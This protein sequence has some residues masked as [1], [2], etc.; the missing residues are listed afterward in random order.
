MKNIIRFAKFSGTIGLIICC[1]GWGRMGHNKPVSATQSDYEVR[2]IVPPIINEKHLGRRIICHRAM[3]IGTPRMEVE[4]I[5]KKIVAHNYGHGGSGWTLG[6]GSATYVNAALEHYAKN[7]TTDTPVTIIGAGA[8]GMFTAYDLLQKGYTKIT[9][10]AENFDSLTSHNAG[11]L[12]AP[13]SMDNAPQIQPTIDKIGI[14]AYLFFADIAN[15]AHAHFKEGAVKVPTYWENRED[16]GLEPYVTA[17]IMQPA[18]EVLLDFGNGTTRKMVSYDDGIFVDTAGMM[19]ALNR[20]ILPKI[21]VIRKKVINFNEI[22]DTYIINCA[23]L[24]ARDLVGDNKVVS[25]Q[26]HLIMLKNQEINDLQ[27]MIL[28]YLDAGKT[29]SGQKIKRSFYIFPK[30]LQGS[31]NNDLGVLGGTFIENAT[32]DTPNTEEFDIIIQ[33]AK[34]FYGIK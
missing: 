25:I 2:K 31:G 9:L 24:G 15:N 34:N 13:V 4:K 23:G 7:L 8:L 26:G 32:V 27:Y 28:I 20:Y 17:G 16:S 5:G 3:R 21:K 30:K 18:R 12:I 1:S 6:P 14:D 33:N 11:G 29:A 10:I 19:K 22:V